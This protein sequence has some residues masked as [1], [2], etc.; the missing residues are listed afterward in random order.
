M[1]HVPTM[2]EEMVH[3]EGYDDEDEGCDAE[4]LGLLVEEAV[5]NEK[6]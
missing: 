4:G 1:S 2:G 5:A 6:S 3:E